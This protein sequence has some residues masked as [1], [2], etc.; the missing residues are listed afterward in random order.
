MSEELA[1]YNRD[2]NAGSE[3]TAHSFVPEYG[4][5]VN[6]KYEDVYLNGGDNS[7]MKFVFGVNNTSMDINLKFSNKTEDE[8]NSFLSL[9]EDTSQKISGNLDF[10]TQTA[11]G[12][13]IAFPTGNIYKNLEDFLIKD[14]SFNFHN[15]VFDI[16]LNLQKNSYSFIFDWSGSAYLDKDKVQNN[17][18]ESRTYEKFDIVYFP[19]YDLSSSPFA[20]GQVNRIEKFYYCV[21]GHTSTINNSPTG[22]TGDHVWKQSFF[23]DLD[24]DV[25]ISADK[26]NLILNSNRSFLIYNKVNQNEGLIKGLRINLKNRSNKETRAIIHFIE[27]HENGRP[28]E[29]SIPQLYKKRKFFIAKSMKHTFVYKDCNDITIEIDETLR[30]QKD[31]FLN[32]FYHAN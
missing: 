14:Y 21:S 4:S 24:D 15:N 6:F 11:S 17:W 29:L 2:L 26:N 30:Y 1:I 20:N 25:T 19:E 5:S 18:S 31:T 23:S 22:V 32:S 3:I 12:V 8:A 28:F 13:E 27:K 16:D 7:A 10:N 9:I